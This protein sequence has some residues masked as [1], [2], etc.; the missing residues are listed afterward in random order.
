MYVAIS[1]DLKRR[2]QDRIKKMKTAEIEASAPQFDKAYPVDASDIF[3]LASFEGRLDVLQAIP[4]DWLRKASDSSMKIDYF[5]D[6]KTAHTTSIRFSELKTAYFRPATEYYGYSGDVRLSFQ[7]VLAM[8]EGTPGRAEII[9]RV[10]DAKLV[11]ELESRW[12]RIKKDVLELLDK[13]KSLNE[14]VKLLPSIKLYVDK[15][16]LERL[17][18]KVE[19]KKRE[20]VTLNIDSDTITAA[21]IAARMQGTI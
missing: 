3:N 13:C 5:D 9:E 12:D 11:R 19:T 7:Q 1:V 20:T 6:D 17:E 2:V 15:D 16:D 4:K 14:A 8:P 10:A 18:R 21:A